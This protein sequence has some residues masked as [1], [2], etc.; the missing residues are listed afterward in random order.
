[1][2][3]EILHHPSQTAEP[4]LPF[5]EALLEPVLN[6]WEKPSSVPA[7]SRNLARRYKAA[8]GDPTF[9]TTHPSPESLVVQV[10]CS[11]GLGSG[12]F[13]TTLSYRESKK[14]EQVAK[15]VF[16]SGS[17]ALKSLNPV[18]ILGRYAHAL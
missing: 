12:A 4:I 1:M 15:K 9:L 7:V 6:V 8:S 5:H 13:P 10:S 2:L 17:M 11:K 16:S 3:T 18:C 14:H